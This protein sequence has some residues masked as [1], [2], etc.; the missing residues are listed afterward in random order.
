MNL[1][2]LL[3]P[4]LLIL[5]LTPVRRG[6]D[7]KLTR[8]RKVKFKKMSSLTTGSKPILKELLVRN[9]T[10][11]NLRLRNKAKEDLVDQKG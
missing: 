9:E 3:V 5:I 2:F 7:S 11:L 6:I 1:R 8:N 4:R 10:G